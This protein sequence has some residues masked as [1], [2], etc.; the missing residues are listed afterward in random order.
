MRNLMQ[1][2]LAKATEDSAKAITVVRVELGALSHMDAA[3]FKE[4]FIEEARGTI[5]ENATIIATISEDS[6]AANAHFV[7]LKSIDVCY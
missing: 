3:H 4:H 2:I 6:S 1:T 7:T 5:A